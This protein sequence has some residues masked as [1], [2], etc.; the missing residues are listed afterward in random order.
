[1][2]LIK[3]EFN[4]LNSPKY[5]RNYLHIIFIQNYFDH[6][7][8]KNNFMHVEVCSCTIGINYFMYI[9]CPC[10]NI[11]SASLC[12]FRVLWLCYTGTDNA[13]RQC[14]CLICLSSMVQDLPFYFPANHFT[15]V[16]GTSIPMDFNITME[17]TNLVVGVSGIIPR[18]T[19]QEQLK[20]KHFGSPVP[21]DFPGYNAPLWFFPFWSSEPFTYAASLLALTQ[22]RAFYDSLNHAQH[23]QYCQHVDCGT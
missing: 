23:K 11:E 14:V 20:E 22:Y 2:D 1:M 16:N 4:L 5:T 12:K 10:Y 18:A 6:S 15:F 8:H 9:N 7:L 19:Y 13:W 21:V 3:Y 17:D